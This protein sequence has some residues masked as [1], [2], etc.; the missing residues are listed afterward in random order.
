MNAVK[1]YQNVSY[2]SPEQGCAKLFDS[3]VDIR[4]ITVGG[5]RDDHGSGSSR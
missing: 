5:D 1:Y 2:T 4:R 3:L